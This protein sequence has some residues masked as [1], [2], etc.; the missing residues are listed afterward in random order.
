MALLKPGGVLG[1]IDH[2]G[3]ADKDNVNLHRLDVAAARPV[4]EAA[5]FAMTESDLLRNPEDDHSA[6]VF[7]PTIRGKT[8]RVLYKLVKTGVATRR[9]GRAR[10]SASTR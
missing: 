4:L 7:S 8:D 10:A 3:D 1:V 9:F 5:G 6:M 2:V